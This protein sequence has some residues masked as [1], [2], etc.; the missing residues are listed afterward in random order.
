MGL[1][2]LSMC[3]QWEV[4]TDPV[5]AGWWRLVGWL[6][7]QNKRRFFFFFIIV[8]LAGVSQHIGPSNAMRKECSIVGIFH[9]SNEGFQL[10]H[11]HPNT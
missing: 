5:L 8:F 6:G 3:N 4:I 11:V 7:A 9:P 2:S 10:G 1:F